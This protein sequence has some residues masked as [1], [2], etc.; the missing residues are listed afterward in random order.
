M[1][2]RIGKALVGHGQPAF[3][4]AE[5]S[6]N[7]A[8]S[9]ERAL[10]IVRAAKRAGADAI[11]LQTYTADTITLRCDRDDFR[12]PDASPWASHS[13]LWDLYNEAHTPWDWHPVIFQEARRLGLEVFSSPFDA[14]AVDFLE[15][16]GAPAYKI[17]SPEITD[18]PLL[19]RVAATGKPVIISLGVA[20]PG[21][22]SLALDTLRA[23]GAN[24]IVVLKCTS[25]Y[26]APVE[27][28]NL[29]TIADIPIRFGALSG[30]SDHTP[31][32]LAA[33]A[34]ICLGAN[35]VEK[36]FTLSD[37]EE[38]VDSFFSLD[39]NQFS[40][41]VRDV[42]WVEKAMGCVSYDISPSSELSLRGRRSLY[43]SATVK[44]GE[45]FTHDNVK[46]VRPAFGMHPKHYHDVIGRHASRDLEL[47][48]RLDWDA[49][50]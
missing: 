3:M 49:I 25:A 20:C 8:G 16:L 48:D 18:I 45:L 7:H 40:S 41:M 50:A 33:V 28:A 15:S 31:G 35:V 11:K 43:V 36:H 23:K 22:I 34:A 27:E 4:I 47:G 12:L 46:S 9:L 21:D 38:S 30:L 2:I 1:Q 6:G 37:G 17:A 29:Q 39:E 26:P 42:R 14:S 32:T 5:M 44:K 19:E 10:D 13:T 24:E